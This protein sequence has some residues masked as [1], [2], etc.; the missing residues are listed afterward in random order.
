MDNDHAT[1]KQLQPSPEHANNQVSPPHKLAHKTPI[2]HQITTRSPRI[3]DAAQKQLIRRSHQAET[4]IPGST[5]RVK[6]QAVEVSAL[7]RMADKARFSL[8]ES[9]RCSLDRPFGGSRVPE[10]R[11]DRWEARVL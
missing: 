2:L 8:T 7:G 9:F 3:Q 1:P 10:V 6:F 11:V 4:G 5:I